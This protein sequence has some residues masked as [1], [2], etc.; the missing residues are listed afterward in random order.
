MTFKET[1][2]Q[3]I[4]KILSELSKDILLDPETMFKISE[5]SQ[6]VPLYPG[7]FISCIERMV[8]RKELEELKPGEILCISTPDGL[9]QGEFECLLDD[10]ILLKNALFLQKNPKLKINKNKI[11]NIKSIDFKILQKTWKSLVKQDE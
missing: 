10:E 7:I 11:Q 6:K 4:I 9:I 8:E 5:M 2:L 1:E 3:D